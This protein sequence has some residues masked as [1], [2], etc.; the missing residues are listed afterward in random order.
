MSVKKNKSSSY[1]RGNLK[2]INS[3]LPI[4]STPAPDGG[5]ND[6]GQH[7]RSPR[8]G[9]CDL[10]TVCCH[11][12]NIKQICPPLISQV[13]CLQL[14]CAEERYR[15]NFANKGA[16]Q[17]VHFFAAVEPHRVKGRGNFYSCMT[18]LPY[19][20][21]NSVKGLSAADCKVINALNIIWILAWKSRQTANISF[22]PQFCL[23]ISHGSSSVMS[24]NPPHQSHQAQSHRWA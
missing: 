16:V 20:Q 24:L 22:Y 17:V 8:R 9:S 12:P 2:R 1:T 3:S 4:T 13:I 19:Q 6:G 21:R 18:I 5:A 15:A 23:K 14:V 10:I 11:E 7:S